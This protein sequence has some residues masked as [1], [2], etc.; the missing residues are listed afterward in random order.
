MRWGGFYSMSSFNNRISNERVSLINVAHLVTIRL[1]MLITHDCLANTRNHNMEPFIVVH[2]VFLLP[3]IG[4]ACANEKQLLIIAAPPQRAVTAD[5]AFALAARRRGQRVGSRRKR[6]PSCGGGR[7]SNVSCVH[8]CVCFC[9]R[10]LH[11]SGSRLPA[12]RLF[13]WACVHV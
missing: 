1:R 3:A 6:A 8:S 13:V 9:V 2:A 11:V 5:S 10:W 4:F 12:V 7:M